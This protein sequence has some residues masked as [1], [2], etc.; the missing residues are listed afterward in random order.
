M[1]TSTV[2]FRTFR[3]VWSS[4]K[5]PVRAGGGIRVDDF[6]GEAHYHLTQC[7][8]YGWSCDGVVLGV[9][10]S[11]QGKSRGCAGNQHTE[12]TDA[13]DPTQIVYE[14]KSGEENLFV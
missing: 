6:T 11:N 14:R 1:P 5:P 10:M 13:T 8:Q 4:W 3:G 2:Q 9:K 12:D 7:R